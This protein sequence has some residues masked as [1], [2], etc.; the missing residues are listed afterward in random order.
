MSIGHPSIANFP[1]YIGNGSAQR[2]LPYNRY[3]TSNLDPLQS[4]ES[5]IL[6][7]SRSNFG[8]ESMPTSDRS[9]HLMALMPPGYDI[10]GN[11]PPSGF[12]YGGLQNPYCDSQLGEA[13]SRNVGYPQNPNPGMDL[14]DSLLES[15]FQ[16]P[17]YHCQPFQASRIGSANNTDI[18]NGWF[19]QEPS[20]SYPCPDGINIDK[21]STSIGQATKVAHPQTA[22]EDGDSCTG[23]RVGNAPSTVNLKLEGTSK[24][25]SKGKGTRHNIASRSFRSASSKKEN[26]PKEAKWPF[27]AQK[28]DTASGEPEAMGTKRRRRTAEEKRETA[29]IRKL[30]GA[31][32]GCRRKHRRCSPNHHQRG[33]PLSTQHATNS[34]QVFIKPVPTFPGYFH[35][36]YPTTG[37]MSIT[38]STPVAQQEIGAA[39]QLSLNHATFAI[40]R[41]GANSGRITTK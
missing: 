20:D 23:Q 25:A 29:Q 19:P 5:Q 11:L 12:Q 1:D 34:P 31:C 8:Q 7:T 18:F 36:F 40:A 30:G 6:N 4:D 28:F 15:G 13:F 32:E 3:R 9:S 17:H 14:E 27:I 35:G 10:Y 21:H 41:M 26:R 22:P 38:A 16:I 37:N 33:A 2:T 39:A 24:K